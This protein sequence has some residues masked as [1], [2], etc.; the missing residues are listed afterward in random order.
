MGRILGVLGGMGPLATVDLLDKIIR[1]TPAK[2]DQDHI[3]V[4]TASIPQIPDRNDAI[5]RNGTSPL[6]AMIEVIRL[7]ERAGANTIAI[8]CNAAHYWH[9]D[10][11]RNTKLPILHIAEAAIT[12]MANGNAVK[13]YPVG[14]LASTGTLNVNIYQDRLTAAGMHCVEPDASVQEDLVMDGIW[15][16]KAG[17]L[18]NGSAKLTDAAD[19]LRS[20]GAEKIILACT[21]VPVA[22]SYA[23]YPDDVYIDATDALA[24]ACVTWAQ[25]P[26]TTTMQEGAGAII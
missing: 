10:L 22:L 23:R 25:S 16:I 15:D 19:H 13:N 18:P 1:A 5:L 20:R 17:D 12:L 4:I 9:D 8:P 26:D 6:A 14:V 24:K 2:L 11:Q 7:L 21:E 3:P